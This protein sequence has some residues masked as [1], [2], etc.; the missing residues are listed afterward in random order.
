[1]RIHLLR[2]KRLLD[3]FQNSLTQVPPAP[4]NVTVTEINLKI[5]AI[6]E[7]R[8]NNFRTYND[9]ATIYLDRNGLQVIQF[10]PFTAR[11][12][13]FHLTK[14]VADPANFDLPL[15]WCIYWSSCPDPPWL[16]YCQRQQLIF[17]TKY[18]YA[19]FRNRHR[20]QVPTSV[21]ITFSVIC[22]Y[23][24]TK[25]SD[26]SRRSGS[27]SLKVEDFETRQERNKQFS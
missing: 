21:L 5:N 13:K 7:I 23:G 27:R 25:V 6:Q 8:L 16:Q 4:N 20:C 11:L 19:V 26:H 3:F 1:M 9:L 14:A 24:P 12:R 10:G 22:R 18:L 15:L 17:T 2:S